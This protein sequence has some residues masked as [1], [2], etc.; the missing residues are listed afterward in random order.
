MLCAVWCCQTELGVTG[1]CCVVF[2]D[3]AG[4]YS[5]CCVLCGVVRLSW[6][7]QPVLCAV[8]CCQTELGVT[9]CAVCC[10]V[11]SD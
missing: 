2:S 9:A 11:L 1:V 10:V 5:L 8:W 4:G 7:L 6:G 3:W